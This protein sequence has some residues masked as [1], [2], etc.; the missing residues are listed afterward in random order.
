V[1][2]VTP[3]AL[4]ETSNPVH[5]LPTDEWVATRETAVRQWY[6]NLARLLGL[7]FRLDPNTPRDTC[8]EVFAAALTMAVPQRPWAAPSDLDETAASIQCLLLE[9]ALPEELAALSLEARASLLLTLPADAKLVL[10]RRLWAAASVVPHA[11]GTLAVS[12][13]S[14]AAR[15]AC[16]ALPSS[17]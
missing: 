9:H 8:P 3:G 13:T 4:P 5:G 1:A 15:C 6:G 11:P 12:D 16:D 10:L 2:T 7:G 14:C 17:R